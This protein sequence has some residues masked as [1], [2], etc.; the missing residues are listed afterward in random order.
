MHD[1][2]NRGDN[3]AHLTE[4]DQHLAAMQDLTAAM[5]TGGATLQERVEPVL[6]TGR[7]HLNSSNGH[8]AAVSEGV[9]TIL[10]SSGS[11]PGI[12]A[13]IE[14]PLSDTYCKQLLGSLESMS[15]PPQANQ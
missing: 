13:G 14:R 12:T 10:A 2:E 4:R 3:S 6:A 11:A 9:H 15:F 8:V 1:M 7:K 5:S